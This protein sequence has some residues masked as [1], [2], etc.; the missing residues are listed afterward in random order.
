MFL[1]FLILSFIEVLGI[2]LIGPYLSLVFTNDS[3]FLVDLSEF[4]SGYF[5]NDNEALIF[6][7]FVLIMIFVVK[8]ITAFFVNYKIIDFSRGLHL[9]MHTSL[10]KRYLNQEYIEYCNRNSSE[11]VYSLQHLVRSFCSDSVINLLKLFCEV[12]F[13]IF[14]IILLAYVNIIL[15]ITWIF[16][17]FIVVFLYDLILKKRFVKAGEKTNYYASILIKNINETIRGYKE[18]KIMRDDE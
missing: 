5:K 2:S 4:T 3:S 12:L 15:F 10:L 16:V 14:I 17:T 13:L 18:I 11:Y 8:T 9:D 1:C 6:L 7:G